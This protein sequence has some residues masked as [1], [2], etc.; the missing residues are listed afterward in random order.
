MTCQLHISVSP[1]IVVH[2]YNKN[3]NYISQFSIINESITFIEIGGKCSGAK[4]MI[5]LVQLLI[6]SI[7]YILEN[8]L[9]CWWKLSQQR[10]F[11]Q[12]V[13]LDRPG[14]EKLEHLQSHR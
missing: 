13:C 10:L 11:H 1:Q 8:G 3:Y 9:L 2:N 4:E 12:A 6:L 7:A 5:A 14:N